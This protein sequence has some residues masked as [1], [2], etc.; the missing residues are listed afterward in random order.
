MLI[1][2]TGCGGEDMDYKKACSEK[3]WP[4]AYSIVDN[5]CGSSGT[6]TVSP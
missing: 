5:L 3:D 6:V 4:K 1:N 2:L